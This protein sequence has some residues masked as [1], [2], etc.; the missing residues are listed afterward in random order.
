M[1]TQ[2]EKQALYIIAS[3]YSIDECAEIMSISRS[4]VEKHLL[5]AKRKLGARTLCGAVYKASKQGLIVLC[6]V[7]VMNA[8]ECRR[9]SRSGRREI[10]MPALII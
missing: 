8:T 5:K 10:E 3:G 6:C 4:G 1:I 2:R 7:L 9:V